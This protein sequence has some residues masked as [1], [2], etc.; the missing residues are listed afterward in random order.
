MV[1][2]RIGGLA[3]QTIDRLQPTDQ[4]SFDLQKDTAQRN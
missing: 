4:I 1:G 2:R 3:R